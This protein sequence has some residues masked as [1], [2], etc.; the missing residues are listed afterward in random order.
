M[1]LVGLG[2]EGTLGDGTK[3]DTMMAQNSLKLVEVSGT[4]G[5]FSSFAF[6]SLIFACRYLQVV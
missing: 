2:I 3:A 1:V 4:V 5:P 6:S